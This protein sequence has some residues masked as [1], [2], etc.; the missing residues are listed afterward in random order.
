MCNFLP[1]LPGKVATSR[2]H[3][4]QYIHQ[5]TLFF[6]CFCVWQFKQTV[7]RP[8]HSL[9]FL[10]GYPF[11]LTTEQKLDPLTVLQ[12]C[13]GGEKTKKWKKDAKAMGFWQ[14]KRS[15]QSRTQIPSRKPSDFQLCFSFSEKVTRRNLSFLWIVWHPKK[16]GESGMGPRKLPTEPRSVTAY[17]KNTHQFHKQTAGCRCRRWVIH[18]S[19]GAWSNKTHLRPSPSSPTHLPK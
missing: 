3:S 10:K 9:V 12:S 7:V 11:M 4:L 13:F 15:H 1:K 8:R 16:L 19:P 2:W 6:R 17:G 18:P 5:N 14:P